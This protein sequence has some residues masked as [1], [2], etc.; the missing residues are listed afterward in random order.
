MAGGD[1]ARWND[2]EQRWE[3]G[4]A[5]ARRPPSVPLEPPAAAPV[6]PA[7]P[8]VPPEYPGAPAASDPYAEYAEYAETGPGVAHGP[9][10]SYNNLT[11]TYPKPA[12]RSVRDR[13]TPAAAGLAVAVLAAGAAGLW[14]TLGGADE[15]GRDDARG[16]TASAPAE[17]HGGPAD[18]ESGDGGDP[19]EIPSDASETASPDAPPPGYVTQDDAEGFR[20]T[21]PEEWGERS[22]EGGAVFYKPFGGAELMQ[23]FRVSEPG[24]TA[25]GAVTAASEELSGRPGFEEVRVGAV[26]SP[27]GGEAAELVYAYDSDESGGRRQVVERVFTASDGRLYAVLVGAPDSQWPRHEEI[28]ERAVTDFDPYDSPF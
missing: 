5:D 6:V 1:G 14:F 15:G 28:L 22:E 4:A 24:M 3:S 13:I 11:G 25:L 2:E 9:A 8:A 16:R 20:I 26:D 12:S 21:V 19:A 7:A 23:I 17:E 10:G 27:S 18:P